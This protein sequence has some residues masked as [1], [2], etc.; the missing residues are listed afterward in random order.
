M[1]ININDRQEI[2]LVAVS[3]VYHIELK[4]KVMRA[5]KYLLMSV[6]VFSSLCGFSQ[7]QRTRRADAEER[8]VDVTGKVV[9]QGNK[10]PVEQATVRLLG[11]RDSLF[12]KGVASSANGTFTL[13]GVQ[14]GSY[15][16]H[17]SF[18]G[19]EPL[20]QP[21]NI[22]G[23][24]N[25][26]QVGNM[27]LSDGAI[28]L[29]EAVVLGKAPDVV[30]HNDTTEYN[31]DSYKVT[32]GSMLEDLL[33]KMPGVE[34]STEGKI[35]VNGKE[36]K[37]I[38]V[39]GKEFFSDDP[40]VASKNLPS[41]MVDKVQVLDRLS[42]MSRM[43]GFDDGNE[44]TVMNLT[45]KP[46]MK[47]G[48]F[49]NAFGGYGGQDRYEG[50]AMVNRFVDSDQV[51]VMGG[52]NNTNNMGFSDFASTMF[53]GMGGGGRRNFRGTG[54]GSGITSSGNV[55]TNFNKEF[56]KKL[57]LNGNAR[58][59][60]SDNETEGKTHRENILPGDSSSYE[61]ENSYSNNRS[62]NIGA[63]FR[64]EWSPDTLTKFIFRPDFGY[65]RSH[66]EGINNT[67]MLDGNRDTVNVGNTSNYSDGEGYNV[68]LNLEFSRKLNSKG[69][70]LSGSVSGGISDT[71]SN[72]MDFSYINYANR[73]DIDINQRIRYD[74]TGYNY[75]AYLSLVEPLG[76]NNF[77]QATYS[78]SQRR[79]E[80]LKNAYKQSEL[81]NDYSIIDTLQSQNYRNDFI[82]QRA[83][84]S[85][86]S[87]RAKYEYTVGFN[88]DPSYNSSENFIGDKTLSELS[89]NVVNFSPMA[90][91]R[92]NFNRQRNLRIDY[93]GTT[94]QPS[95]TQMQPVADYA[96][97]TNIKIGN[98][99]LKP[100]Y[101]N[102]M[103][104]RLQSFNQESQFA[105][106]LISDGG[107]VVNEIV[108]YIINDNDGSGNRTTTYKNIGGNY[109]GN[110]RLMLNS[111]LTN[112]KFSVN[113]MSVASFANTNGIIGKRSG[114]VITDS[115]NTNKN[116]TLM[117][118][119]GIDFRSTHLDL[120]VN[121][122]IRY[123]KISNS[124]QKESN[125]NVFNYGVGG[126]T[127]IYLPG[128]FKIE[129]DI[130]WSTNS[131][132]T[133]GF[134]LNE[135]LWNASASKSFL[136]GNAATIRLKMYDILQQRSN[137]SRS[138]TANYIQDSEYNTLSS[139]F[140]VH[141]IYKFSAFK[142]NAG[143]NDVFGG[144]RRNFDGPPSGGERRF[145]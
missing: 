5:G 16:L 54:N 60:H 18:I 63:N 89:R 103:T 99:D 145:Y 84:L 39:D 109:N 94:S 140:M 79:Q 35:T 88:V 116:L 55:G 95:L 14:P 83:S 3:C 53:Q 134:E 81:P 12:V 118:R 100:R 133:D 76:N 15:L 139:Y 85:F 43:T 31:A 108:N 120:G 102:K 132:Y 50:N 113:S 126:L 135:I 69:R 121:G 61:S 21:L 107:F 72:G 128:N 52:A 73:D 64:M 141:L 90:Q 48:W 40:K 30:V 125:Q 142:G 11:S 25:P 97:P 122:N 44:E 34:V 10:S 20:Y 29:G 106:M 82:N 51:T 62:D 70:T 143:V 92:Y 131:G 38:L 24:T 138:V 26:V 75:R 119:G 42:E 7:Q 124:L 78:F 33:K 45:V 66:Q 19:Y 2:K 137:I 115:K 1:L 46:G 86:K 127:T 110:L 28:E 36:I 49:G 56:D 23:R 136:K 67:S 130:N 112:R 111:P 4:N 13:K 58:Y 68:N 6:C 37:K 77:L 9:E 91:F 96:D 80:S 144:R 59:S 98:P 27:E 41:N 87:I 114:D 32:E 123:N 129:S 117:E 104:I 74:N 47:E 105:Y 8:R 17:I 65:S 57:T 71:Y 93:N 101:E 22:T